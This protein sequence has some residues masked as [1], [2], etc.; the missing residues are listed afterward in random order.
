MIVKWPG[1]TRPGSIETT[2]V[3]IEDFFPSLIDMAGAGRPRVVQAVDG[4]SFVPLLRRTAGAPKDRALFWHFPNNWG[5]KGPGIGASS[6]V[7]LGDWKL[8]YYHADRRFEL[9]DLAHD[10]G[11]TTNLAEGQPEKVRALA[12][13]LTQHLVSAGAQMPTDKAT[14]RAVPWPSEA[15]AG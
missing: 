3:I 14:G 8:I 13:R 5:P 1:V 10:L 2:P 15:T 12:A 4:V 9:F 11:E 7:R 6:T